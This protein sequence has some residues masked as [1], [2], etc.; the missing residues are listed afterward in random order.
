MSAA[1]T[2][3]LRYD[4]AHLYGLDADAFDDFSDSA[5]S[6]R[7]RA[8]VQSMINTI[9]ALPTAPHSADGGRLI[10]LPADSAIPL[11]RA[12]PPPSAPV[13][14]K[15]EQF[16]K[17][18]GIRGRKRGRLAY[19]ETTGQWAPRFGYKRADDAF[20]ESVIEAR[21]GDA[22]DEATGAVVDPW[23]AQDRARKKRSDANAAKRTRNLSA[24]AGRNR[25]PGAIDLVSASAETRPR[26]RSANHVDVAL[27]VAQQSTASVGAF[28]DRR[29]DEPKAKRI[30][31][32]R[33]APPP[34]PPSLASEKSS[35]LAILTRLFGAESESDRIPIE[36]AVGA[37]QATQDNRRR[38]A[39]LGA[40]KAR[41]NK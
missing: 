14:T 16:A 15:W 12:L 8:N 1:T 31:S 7:S 37:A 18:K 4:L 6:V 38:A 34:P 27:N 28:D 17:A 36:K 35:Q 26:Q 25:A 11:P 2:T 40:K 22:V 10:S 33:G 20:N 5:L 30:R 29:F 19:D 32:E 3:T 21:S 41:P 24:A 9:F 13:P 23:T 39:K